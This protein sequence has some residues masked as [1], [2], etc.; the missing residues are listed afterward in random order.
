MQVTLFTA[1]CS[2]GLDLVGIGDVVG[3]RYQV[4]LLMW[5][6][7]TLS[8]N[9]CAHKQKETGK[10]RKINMKCMIT[11]RIICVFVSLR[12]MSGCGACTHK[13]LKVSINTK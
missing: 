10:W 3:I 7:V 11:E 8:Y 13:H 2:A 1:S 4:T 5:G 6:T 9:S 12:N